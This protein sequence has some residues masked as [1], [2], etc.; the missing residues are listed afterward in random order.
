MSVKT[1]ILTGAASGMGRAMAIGLVNAGH[2]V[3]A[4][5]RDAAALESLA[6]LTEAP[7]GLHIQH[8]DL[9]DDS[10]A[11]AIVAHALQVFGR[12]DALVNNAGINLMSHRR[13]RVA[14]RPRFWELDAQVV[15][16]FSEINTLAPFKLTAAVAPHMIDAGSGRIVNVTTS[17]VAMLTSG[18]APYGPTKAATESMSAIMAADLAGTGVTVN[19]LLPGG[20]VDTPMVGDDPPI[21][22]ALLLPTDTMLAPLLWLI[23]DGAAKVSGRRFI[24]RLWDPSVPAEVAAH[25]ASAAIG[26]PT[27]AGEK[28]VP[29]PNDT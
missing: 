15:R 16:L 24:S 22:R 5:D 26:W 9:T 25:R 27:D 1:I 7:D 11:A 19:V 21:A 4:V 17:L 3:L 28:W 20:P 14:L 29:K 23:S 8:A 13:S 12:I 18:M 10:S 6:A 2:R